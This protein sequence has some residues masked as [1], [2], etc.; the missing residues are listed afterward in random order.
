MRANKKTSLIPRQLRQDQ[1]TKEEDKPLLN[2]SAGLINLQVA[3]S[4]GFP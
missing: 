4:L 2:V 3:D 1:E